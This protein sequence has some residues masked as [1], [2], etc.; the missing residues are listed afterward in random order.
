MTYGKSFQRCRAGGDAD[1]LYRHVPGGMVCRIHVEPD[2]GHSYD[3][4]SKVSVYPEPGI[5][6]IDAADLYW[7]RNSYHYSIY[8]VW[9]NV[10]ICGIAGEL[11]CLSDSVHPALHGVGNQPEKSLCAALRRTALKGEFE[12]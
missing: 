5:C 7:N 10:G 2:A 3:P 12:R 1:D 8:R 11:F 4:H 9:K 6:P